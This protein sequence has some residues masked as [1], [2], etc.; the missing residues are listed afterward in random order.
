MDSFHRQ[1]QSSNYHLIFITY[2][3]KNISVFDLNTFQF[4]QQLVII[5]IIIALYQIQKMNNKSAKLSNG[6]NFQLHQLPVCDIKPFLNIHM[7]DI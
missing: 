7:C 6:N 2:F 4:I 5:F 3:L 1:S